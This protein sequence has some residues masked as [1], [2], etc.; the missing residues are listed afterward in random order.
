MA[1]VILMWL[2]TA[3]VLFYQGLYVIRTGQT[4]LFLTK[5]EHRH[6]PVGSLSRLA[7]AFVYWF[8]SVAMFV[9]LATSLKRAGFGPLRAWLGRNSGMLFYALFLGA[10][11]ALQIAKPSM[12]LRWTLRNHPELADDRFALWI[13]RLIG[14]ALLCMAIFMLAK[15]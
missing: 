11:G 7:Y 8:P 4:M 14:L 9:I 1:F 5:R 15:M 12:M 10:A 2:M 6:P 3:G 13:T